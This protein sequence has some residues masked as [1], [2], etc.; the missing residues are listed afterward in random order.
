[1]AQAIIARLTF[2][3]GELL[4]NPEIGVGLVVGTKARDLNAIRDD[5]TRSLLQDPRIESVENFTLSRDGPELRIRFL[6]NIKQVD[7]PV[8]IE[9]ALPVR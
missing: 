5:I 4:N 2:E 6:A 8:P 3:K 1:M 7:Q 9:L